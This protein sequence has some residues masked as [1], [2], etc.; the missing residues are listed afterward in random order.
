[1]QVGDKVVMVSSNPHFGGGGIRL[2]DV[3]Y[4]QKI[5]GT[6]PEDPDPIVWIIFPDHKQWRK[7]T[8]QGFMHEI[9]LYQEEPN[10]E[11]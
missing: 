9:A 4:I 8:W 10:W 2:G 1:M 11:I 5:K 3:G 7:H 6:S